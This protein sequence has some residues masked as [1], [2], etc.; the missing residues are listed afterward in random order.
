MPEYAAHL[1][2][3]VDEC[4]PRLLGLP[5]EAVR[6]RPAPD[7]WSPAEILGHLVDSASNN[8]QRFVRGQLQD[9]LVFPGYDQEAWVEAQRHRDAPWAELVTLWS[10]FNRHLA[11][12]MTAVPPEV[13]DRP[14]TGHNFDVIA[15]RTIPADEPA[16]LG[17]FM[18][19]HVG[20]PEHHLRQILGE[21]LGR[22]ATGQ[23][24]APADG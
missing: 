20:H 23:G 7:K 9:P 12:V 1:L 13:R 10:S 19:D 16:S 17:W 4:T 11:R 6:G 21:D 22:G 15:W 5:E 18:A 24:A 8:H 14:R 2:R 3:L